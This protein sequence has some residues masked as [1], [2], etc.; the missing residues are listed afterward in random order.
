MEKTLQQNR[1]SDREWFEEFK[2][3]E[4]EWRRERRKMPRI[5]DKRKREYREPPPSRSKDNQW[6]TCLKTLEI[7]SVAN[8]KFSYLK[9]KHRKLVLKHPEKHEAK[10]QTEQTILVRA[11]QEADELVK[12][13]VFARG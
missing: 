1:Q 3:E 12:E 8:L 6:R 2:R 13:T 11:I 9:K 5:E 7:D 10:D 4:A